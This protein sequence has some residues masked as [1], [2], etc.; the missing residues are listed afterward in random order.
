MTRTW[1][2]DTINKVGQEVTVNGW[3]H[4]RRNMGKF[5]FIDLRDRTGLLQI[6]F[7]PNGGKASG[8]PEALPPFGAKTI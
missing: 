6:V 1:V 5:I 3:V 4:A 2:A 7:A 8:A